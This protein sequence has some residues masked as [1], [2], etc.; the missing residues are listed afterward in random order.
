MTVQTAVKHKDFVNFYFLEHD[1][2]TY[3]KYD[4]W[5]LDIQLEEYGFE[6]T[7]IGFVYPGYSNDTLDIAV[8]T[9]E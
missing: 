3:K 2:F 9:N 6:K 8:E 4:Q 1:D 5:I 7:Q